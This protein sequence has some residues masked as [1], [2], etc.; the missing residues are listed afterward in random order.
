VSNDIIAYTHWSYFPDEASA[1]RC[2]EADL[3]DY[4]T[5][6]REPVEGGGPGWLLL[7][8]RDVA[9][10]DLV[11]RHEEVAEIV[12]RHGG[13]YDGGEATY[14]PGGVMAD[15]MLTGEWG[16]TSSG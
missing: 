2:V 12:E 5:R 10:A 7:A 1:Q 9:I 3:G 11:E 16:A 8:G 15:P 13:M 14:G 4:V 6:V